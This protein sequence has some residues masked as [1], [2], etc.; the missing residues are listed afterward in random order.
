MDKKLPIFLSKL[1]NWNYL[2]RINILA[3]KDIYSFLPVYKQIYEQGV[4]F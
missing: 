3:D 2:S 4:L 1:C